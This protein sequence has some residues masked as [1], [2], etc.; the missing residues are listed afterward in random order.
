[1]IK[2]LKN[3]F[4]SYIDL[5]QLLIRIFEKFFHC[6]KAEIMAGHY[7]RCPRALHRPLRFYTGQKP[8]C[9]CHFGNTGGWWGVFEFSD[10]TL[11]GPYIC[12]GKSKKIVT[13]GG[14]VGLQKGHK[15][16]DVIC[17]RSQCSGIINAL[18]VLGLK[19]LPPLRAGTGRVREW[20]FLPSFVRWP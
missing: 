17:E 1:M 10:K 16:S 13:G 20:S 6:W 11:P 12:I 9:Q 18:H 19:Y 8:V 2:S 7:G 15:M 4:N 5:T 14:G 3:A